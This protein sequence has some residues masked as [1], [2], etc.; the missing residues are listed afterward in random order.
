VVQFDPTSLRATHL[1]QYFGLEGAAGEIVTR[2]PPPVAIADGEVRNDV[3]AALSRSVAIEGRVLDGQ[4]EPV[5]Y[6]AVTAEVEGTREGEGGFA[7]KA[8]GGSASPSTDD[9]GFFRLFGLRP[10][11]YRVCA[12][13]SSGVFATDGTASRQVRTCYPSSLDSNS[14]SVVLT[15]QD[16]GGID[17]RLQRKRAFR[18]SGVAIDSSG[19]P[20]LRSSI[21]LVPS[22]N[23][24]NRSD[25]G[26]AEVRDG[27]RFIITGVT[28]GDYIV[29]VFF[30]APFNSDDKRHQENG[31]QSI[32][33]DD[34]DIDDIVITTSKT[35]GVRGRIVFEDPV[36]A[37]TA[38]MAVFATPPPEDP[39]G[40]WESSV[41][42]NDDRTFELT[43]LLGPRI[44]KVN[45]EPRGWI[46]D[47]IVLGT[48]DITD[49]VFD[50]K[51]GMEPQILQV[52][53]SRRGA[54]LSGRVVGS[55]QENP[56]NSVVLIS[57]DPE[58][59]RLKM[60]V[61]LMV[62]PKADGSFA[63]KPVRAGEYVIA[64][65]IEDYG[66]W[67][68]EPVGDELERLVENG[69]R[70]TL[71]EGEKRELEVRVVKP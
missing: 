47:R 21:N 55:P 38:E 49:K 32:H 43:G 48:E 71:V 68:P 54:T 13:P 60:G 24:R 52:R 2:P 51:T 20:A 34:T 57:A 29:Q 62:R 63:L 41:G 40:S 61:A 33:I 26:Q 30:G 42:V 19:S 7:R 8:Y 28:P 35:T 15:T 64:A 6:V 36:S 53:M 70:I 1:D 67:A 3:D 18:V 10:G 44:V 45:G 37:S 39:I 59:R 66:N 14:E 31:Y 11:R 4:G 22:K 69:Q 46:V 58:R 56:A 17:I 50:F 9:R 65:S 27:G 12:Y 23:S 5:P 16:V 25:G